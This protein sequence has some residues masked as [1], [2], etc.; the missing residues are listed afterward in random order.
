MKKLCLGILLTLIIC[1][2]K[3]Q[4]TY[5]NNIFIPN[6]TFGSGLSVEATE[7]GYVVFGV[8]RDSIDYTRSVFFMKLDSV[9][10]LMYYKTIS[11]SI[12]T[13]WGG[14]YGSFAMI[15]N[16]GFIGAGNISYPDKHI[17]ILYRFN[18]LGDTL[19][20][21]LFPDTI[22][23]IG[24]IFMHCNLT[25]DNGFVMTGY[26]VV[27]QYNSNM[28]LV[29]T[30]SLG[31]EVF[32]RDY[33]DT[34][35]GN[36]EHGYSVLQA[37]DKGYFL[38]Y[39]HH[40]AGDE[41]STDPVVMKVDS[42]GN[43]EWELNIGGPF[44]DIP[45]HVCLGNDGSLIAGTSVAD[46][47]IQ[48]NIYSRI[49]VTKLS[50]S[51][52]VLWEKMYF[53]TEL[54]NLLNNI[55]PDHDGG[56]IATGYRRN[57]FHPGHWR[58]KYGW[59]LKINEIGDSIWYREFNYY[60]GTESDFNMLYDLCLT[61]DG[62]YAMVGQAYT[63]TNPQAAWIIKVDSFGCDT[64]DCQTVHVEELFG[65]SPKELYVFPNPANNEIN[66]GVKNS[67]S[68]SPYSIIIFDIFGRKQDVIA[69]PKGERNTRI[70]I[71]K[72]PSGV[73]VAIVM[74]GH[75]RIGQGKFVVK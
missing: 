26:R 29:K 35:Y 60:T 2:V 56:Y 3:G 49:Y 59:L 63:W 68:E 72:Y 15:N 37:P 47:S 32:R 7:N 23:N 13:Y 65:N 58:K 41:N 9:G 74:N 14:Y 21:K 10:N 43:F 27:K 36:I 73:Y 12:N 28:I 39:T 1:T 5:F 33:G 57:Y 20:A 71:S 6:N 8:T 53:Q 4:S 40:Y 16:Q 19:W 44:Q 24:S 52:D 67:I 75:K 17:A 51:G 55:Y 31:N 50:V 38:G 42:A 34:T 62:G 54:G 30:D 70:D 25:Y 61:S 46:S 45:P 18:D 64:P 22:A 69:V 11:D 66:I 48:G